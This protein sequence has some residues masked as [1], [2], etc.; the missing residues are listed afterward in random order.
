MAGEPGTKGL[1]RM[2]GTALGGVC[3][4]LAD[5][6]AIDPGIIR[7][8]TVVLC[9]LTLGVGGL[10]YL[11]LWAV[12]PERGN[13]HAHSAVEVDADA[14]HSDVY[15]QVASTRNAQMTSE[16]DDRIAHIALALGVIVLVVA[17]AILFSRTTRLFQPL[18]FWPLAIVAAGV[19]R[20][21]LPDSDGQRLWPF[22]AGAGLLVLGLVTLFDSLGLVMVNWTHWL[23]YGIPLLL[24]AGVL[25]A[26]GWRW[27]Y[28]W[29][30]LIALV[31]LAVFILLGFTLFLGPGPM[32][33]VP[34]NM[35]MRR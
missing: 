18:H 35:F 13:A 14:I 12:L 34:L 1:Y 2:G 21:V 28:S 32:Q 20:M 4:G 8:V 25:Y 6:L 24:S 19:V 15:G 7:M 17:V 5:Y 10:V 26:I 27:R 9:I 16:S 30:K 31:L 22:A 11:V 29:A 23:M 33:E 3:A